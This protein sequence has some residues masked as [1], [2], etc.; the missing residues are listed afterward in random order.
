MKKEDIKEMTKKGMKFGKK[1]MNPKSKA[2]SKMCKQL[3]VRFSVVDSK[4]NL[5]KI[6]ITIG[7]PDCA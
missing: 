5:R 6:I 1:K 2:L 4:Q 3:V 7:F